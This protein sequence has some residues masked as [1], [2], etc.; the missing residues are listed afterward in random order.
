MKQFISQ[1]IVIDDV[2]ESLEYIKDLPIEV[3]LL[4]IV[5]DWL[6]LR[7]PYKKLSPIEVILLGIINGWLKLVHPDKK[8]SPIPITGKL[9]YVKGILKCKL[10]FVWSYIEFE[11]FVIIKYPILTSSQINSKKL[12][13]TLLLLFEHDDTLIGE[14]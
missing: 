5:N 9:L 6:K 8:S 11:K 3:I 4:G 12:F 10:N 1:S 14:V 13:L 2:Y 7:H